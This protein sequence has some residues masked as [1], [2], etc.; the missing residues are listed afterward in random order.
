[1]A[2]QSNSEPQEANDAPTRSHSTVIETEIPVQAISSALQFYAIP[3][4]QGKPCSYR[5]ALLKIRIRDLDFTSLALHWR[6]KKLKFL[7]NDLRYIETNLQ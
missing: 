4:W 7:C 2:H 6:Q 3:L 5:S 1:M